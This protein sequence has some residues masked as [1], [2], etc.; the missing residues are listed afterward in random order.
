MFKKSHTPPNIWPEFSLPH[1]DAQFQPQL[2][3]L[4]IPQKE[5]WSALESI[6]HNKETKILQHLDINQSTSGR[7]AMVAHTSNPSAQK[8]EPEWSLQVK[9]QHG[10]QS[11]FQS[12]LYIN[13]E[14]VST[15]LTPF[16]KRHKTTK[17]GSTFGIIPLI[18]A[19][20]D[21]V[22]KRRKRG[23]W[24][25]RPWFEDCLD[26]KGPVLL[27]CHILWPYYLTESHKEVDKAK[28][29]WSPSLA[30]YL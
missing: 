18:I 3:G 10:L 22:S 23:K 8:A 29:R 15:P 16:R 1:C 17:K 26:L 25:N 2:H 30:A 6:S 13:Q 7:L 12:K 20:S 21:G 24:S 4:I 11:K 27:Y 19:R 5:L 28:G 9:G 14:A